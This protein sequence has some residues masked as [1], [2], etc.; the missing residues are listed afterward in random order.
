MSDL[1]LVVDDEA[2]IALDLTATVEQTGRRVLGPAFSLDHARGLIAKQTPDL[3]L[4][5][6]NVGT[7]VVWP[8]ARELKDRGCGV[9]LISGDGRQRMEEVEFAGLPCLEK[10]T[11]PR[12]V[13]AALDRVVSQRN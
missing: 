11:T 12:D 10:P 13:I 7:E 6:I 3:A 1:V 8:L 5:D 9:I 4:L 2:L